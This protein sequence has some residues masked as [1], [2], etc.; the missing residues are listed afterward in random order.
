MRFADML[1]QARERAGLTQEGLA[2]KTGLP[3]RSL[4]NWEQGHRTPR[5]GVILTL[6][7]ALG[8]SAEGL[9][10][11]LAEDAGRGEPEPKKPRKG[12]KGK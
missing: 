6:A 8:T 9:L 12:R 10:L 2:E 4:Q 1:K 7:R 11:A 5:V 3:L